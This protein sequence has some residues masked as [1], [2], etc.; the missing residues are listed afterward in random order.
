MRLIIILSL[1]LLTACS[2]QSVFYKAEGKNKNFAYKESFLKY[3]EDELN[4]IASNGNGLA[5]CY[6]NDSRKGLRIIKDEFKVNYSAEYLNKIATC[7]MLSKNYSKALFYFQ[8]SLGKDSKNA[9]T[10][11]NIGVLN[12]KLGHYYQAM[13][14]FKKARELS[15][16]A[17]VPKYN[18]ATI[19]IKHAQYDSALQQ[20]RDIYRDSN[21]DLDIIAA[22]GTAYLLKGDF[23]LAKHY[24]TKISSNR[25]SW[26]DIAF[27]K[28]QILIHEGKY[29]EAQKVVENARSIASEDLDE[30]KDSLEQIIQTEFDKKKDQ[31]GNS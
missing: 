28:A 3:N 29:K 6:L 12:A 2:T 15:P 27:Y 8:I 31:K 11:N 16:T 17:K 30:L 26:S 7:Y 22:M 18:L 1:M 25:S 21:Q 23:R 24:F 13:S 5:H 10:Y 20:L 9:K 4:E 14:Y 19:F